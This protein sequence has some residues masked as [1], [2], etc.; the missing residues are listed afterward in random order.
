MIRDASFFKISTATFLQETKKVVPDWDITIIP[1]DVMENP[2]K[3][4]QVKIIVF[5][6]NTGISREGKL[7]LF[8]PKPSH[9][10]PHHL[11]ILS[12]NIAS[13]ICRGTQNDDL[14]LC[15]KICNQISVFF[16]NKS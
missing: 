15:Q 4:N 6:Q 1:S 9:P 11:T 8:P 2:E 3:Y 16:G 5:N 10:P 14:E 7:H 13:L 12:T